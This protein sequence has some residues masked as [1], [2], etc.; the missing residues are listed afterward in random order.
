MQRI[1][2]GILGVGA[3][4]EWAI[5]P[6]LSGPDAWMPPDRGV[7]WQRRP[8]GWGDIAYQ[9]PARPEVV[10]LADADG[11]KLRRVA[12]A[13]RVRAVYK[14]WK[15]MLR[16]APLDALICPQDGVRAHG[17]SIQ[18]ILHEANG[19]IH[20]IWLDGPAAFSTHDAR[21]LI[22]QTRGHKTR[23]WCA[24]P[25]RRAAAHRAA[26]SLAAEKQI[27]EICAVAL[28][29]NGALHPLPLSQGEEARQRFAS[30]YAAL[31]LLLGACA[32]TSSQTQT[33]R[34]LQVL[35][36][37]Q[38]GATNLWLRAAN[39]VC[40]TA[41]FCAADSWNS[42]LPRLELCGTQGRALVCEAGRRLWLHQPNLAAHLMEPPGLS[43]HWSAATTMGVA[44]DLKEFLAA[45]AEERAP[46]LQ[47]ESAPEYCSTKQ[48]SLWPD[49]ATILQLGEAI[50]VSLDENRLVEIEPLEAEP[51]VSDDGRGA[52]VESA[53]DQTLT[54]Q[55]S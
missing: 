25:L 49:T 48:Y 52:V 13:S 29:W 40:V 28:R 19:R 27:G 36:S 43:S 11:E 55:L 17:V 35:A 42:P 2:L 21:A 41:L 37:S 34:P 10:A 31:D 32:A 20:S 9:P 44:E 50:A 33:A 30:T 51:T 46:R 4:T 3:T 5:L 6:A 53:R 39:E 12:G 54:L 24:R 23:L 1:R 7:W 26:W 38:G 15:L 16:E 47:L 8:A 22:R 18:E 45:C 14:D